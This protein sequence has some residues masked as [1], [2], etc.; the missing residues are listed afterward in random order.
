M[1][2]DGVLLEQAEDATEG[3]ACGG[4]GGFEG[5][6]FLEV[7]S[8]LWPAT[9]RLEDARAVEVEV[10]LVWGDSNGLSNQ[11]ERLFW[12][13]ALSA[14]DTQKVQ[15]DRF[16]RVGLEDGAIERLGLLELAA[17]ASYL[18]AAWPTSRT[19]SRAFFTT[20]RFTFFNPK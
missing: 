7:S 1:D 6:G 15:A 11:R 5:E 9:E 2:G 17:L 20:W 12:A 19:P 4:G 13:A 16:E 8:S 3:E 14:D 18:P 10:R